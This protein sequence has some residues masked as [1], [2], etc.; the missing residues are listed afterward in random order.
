MS[1]FK[2]ESGIP[3]PSRGKQKNNEDNIAL[4]RAMAVGDSLFEA[5]NEFNNKHLN[6]LSSRVNYVHG[7][8]SA[9]VRRVEGG[10]RVWRAK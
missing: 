3:L 10:Y 4:I 7:P 1:T 5:T 8:G 9:A 2:I 6:R